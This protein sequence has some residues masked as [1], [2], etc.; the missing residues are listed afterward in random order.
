ME[1][2]ALLLLGLIAMLAIVPPIIRGKLDESPLSTTQNFQRSMQ[3]MANSIESGSS[4][5]R[6]QFSGRR[7]EGYMVAARAGRESRLRPAPAR[8][9]RRTSAAVR[10]SR[11]MAA[12]TVFASIWGAATLISGETWCLI[13]FAVSCALLLVFW[14]LAVIIPGM[15]KKTRAAPRVEEPSRSPWSQAL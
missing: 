4:L 6:S 9:P 2:L 12:L 10:R 14:A 8:N 5:E 11:I 7:P 3:E 15:P 1:I 13:A